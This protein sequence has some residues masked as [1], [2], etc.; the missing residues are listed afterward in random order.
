MRMSGLL[1]CSLWMLCCAWL[2]PAHAAQPLVGGYS[3]GHVASGE[4]P[5][6]NITHDGE[7]YDAETVADAEHAQ[8]WLLGESGRAAFWEK[9]SWPVESSVGA[10]C[11][12]WGTAPLTLH[13]LLE[14]ETTPEPPSEDRV[15]A[16]VLCQVQAADKAK[17][18]WLAD[19]QS[20]YFYYDPLFGVT[21]IRAL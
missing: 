1:R 10:A 20:D 18:D 14:P 5:V 13:A 8:A 3:H 12:T 7:Q 19:Y 9:M 17:I 2:L 6:W 4:S 16:S 15:G 21:E 11:L